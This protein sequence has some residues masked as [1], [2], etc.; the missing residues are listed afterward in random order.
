VWARSGGLLRIGL[1]PVAVLVITLLLIYPLASFLALA[2]FP[3]LFGEGSGGFTL[4]YFAAALNGYAAQALGDSL[5]VGLA[6]GALATALG[7]YLSWLTQRSDLPGR[8]IIDAAAWLVLLMPSYLLAIGWLILLQR[9]GLLNQLGLQALWLQNLFVGPFG[10][11]LVL[12]MKHVPFAYLATAPS[13]NAVGGELEEAALVHG[14]SRFRRSVLLIRLLWPALAAAFAVVFAESLGDF[15]VA[16]TLGA[17]ANFPLATY[18]IYQALYTTPLSFSLAAASSWLLMALS[19]LAVWVQARVGARTARYAVLSGRS[20]PPRR[21]ALPRYARVLAWTTLGA[22]GLCALAVPLL[23]TAFMS[24]TRV[25]AYGF[26]LTNLSLH[27]YAE[28][29][30]HR[31]ILGPLGYSAGMAC[32]A[33][34]AALALGLALAGVLSR[35]SGLAR[36][37]DFALLAAMALPGLVL[38]AGYIFAYNLPFLPLYGTSFLLGMAYAGGAMPSSSRLLLGPLSQV[39]RSLGEAARVHGLRPQVVLGRVTLPILSEPMLY[40][41]LAAAS[42]VMFELPASELLYPPGRPPLSVALIKFVHG[43]N[44]GL[45]TAL[46]VVSV[47][48]VVLVVW[49]LRALF[50]KLAP[51]GWIRRAV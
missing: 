45:S 50:A 31:S 6:S 29:F 32:A 20:R 9:G 41:W 27:N 47:L 12:A 1:L 4:R 38:A 19:A 17:T 49:L 40:A 14:L 7:L 18:A 15:G 3:G 26:S 42:G 46:E 48:A 35:R 33:A 37:L 25:I 28:V 11:I 51:A 44:F 36:G 24:F 43:F 21:V 2:W 16:A 13:W 10:V 39:H 5:L 23:S 34:T 30:A 22:T 8:R